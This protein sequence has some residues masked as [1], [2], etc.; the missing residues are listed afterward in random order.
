MLMHE[1]WQWSMMMHRW[2]WWWWWL[3]MMM[4]NDDGN[5]NTF[6]LPEYLLLQSKRGKFE[7]T[8][9]SNVFLKIRLMLPY[10]WPKG[11]IGRQFLVFVCFLLLCAGRV[12]NLY[13]PVY[14]RDISKLLVK[15]VC[16]FIG[17]GIVSEIIW[18]I[19]DEYATL[20]IHKY[21]HLYVFLSTSFILTQFSSSV[22][23]L[24]NRLWQHAS[25]ILCILNLSF[26]P[27]RCRYDL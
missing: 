25:M 9:W 24:D 16:K 20:E 11:S 5:Q 13:V 18:Y 23:D 8:T 27:R 4:M 26:A 22:I 14:A 1:Q 15:I 2:L 10:I 7:D 12:I 6:L 19:C 3:I 21:S 17:I